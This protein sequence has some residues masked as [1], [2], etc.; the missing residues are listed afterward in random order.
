MQPR[1][2]RKLGLRGR[3]MY[4]DKKMKKME[5]ITFPFS[6]SGLDPNI[7]WLSYLLPH[8]IP[9]LDLSAQLSES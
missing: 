6:N 5:L 2:K 9:H 3:H 4:L 8:S 7:L 1:R